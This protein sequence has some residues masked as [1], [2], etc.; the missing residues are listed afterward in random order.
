MKEEFIVV[1][2]IIILNVN[3]YGWYWF[4]YGWEVQVYVYDNKIR[5]DFDEVGE[6]LCERGVIVQM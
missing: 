4:G 5:V 6:I 1:R 2:G 3:V